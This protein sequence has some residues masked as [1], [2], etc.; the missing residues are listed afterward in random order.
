VAATASE[1]S[2]ASIL[3]RQELPALIVGP[4]HK[5]LAANVPFRKRFTF[6]GDPTGRFCFELVHQSRLP[7]DLAGGRCPLELRGGGAEAVVHRHVTCLGT[8]YD[9]VTAHRLPHADH[10][11]T[12]LLVAKPLVPSHLSRFVLGESPALLRLLEAVDR[13]ASTDLTVVIRGESGT[14]KVCVARLLHELSCRSNGPFV[15]TDCSGVEGSRLGRDLRGRHG[16]A[17][18]DAGGLVAAAAGGTLL[19]L[20]PQHLAPSLQNRL[21]QLLEKRRRDAGNCRWLFA[22]DPT[23]PSPRGDLAAAFAA[24]PSVLVP[25]LR[26]RIEDLPPL[27]ESLVQRFGEARPVEVDPA[28][29]ELLGRYPFP[30]NVRELECLVERACLVAAGGRLGPEHFPASVHV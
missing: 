27:V 11:P 15:S 30:G 18:D 14:G 20:E 24:A 8:T 10:H 6:G 21:G 17:T 22:L 1:S 28:V 2:W 4:T 25:P 26:D 13:A 23:Q 9:Q 5:V 16:G 3:E 7:C 19:V 29:F 12:F